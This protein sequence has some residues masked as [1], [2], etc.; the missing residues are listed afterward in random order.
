MSFRVSS[1][2]A[3]LIYRPK[4]NNVGKS[5][6]MPVDFE[7]TPKDEMKDIVNINVHATL[8][9]THAILPSMVKR[10]AILDN[11]VYIITLTFH[12]DAMV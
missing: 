7:E 12:S 4:V 8:K 3:R 6:N 5:H 10:Q 11:L 2:F 9:V 1:V